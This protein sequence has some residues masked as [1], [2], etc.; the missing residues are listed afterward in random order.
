M[1][2][3]VFAS[4]VRQSLLLHFSLF[5]SH[6]QTRQSLERSMDLWPTPSPSPDANEPS[7]SGPSTRSRSARLGALKGKGFYRRGDFPTCKAVPPTLDGRHTL[8]MAI[9]DDLLCD[10]ASYAHGTLVRGERTEVSKERTID[11]SPISVSAKAQR[12]GTVTHGA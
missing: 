3:K 10:V 6:S 1:I 5:T 12:L 4:S 9:L 8:Q 11:T 7:G 2:E